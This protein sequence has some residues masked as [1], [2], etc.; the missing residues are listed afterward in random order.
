[1]KIAIAIVL[2]LVWIVYTANAC[3][4]DDKPIILHY[5]LGLLLAA[6]WCRIL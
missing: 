3:R 5:F 4:K 2:T 6:F 1:M